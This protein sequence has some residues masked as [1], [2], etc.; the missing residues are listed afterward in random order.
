MKNLFI[1]LACILVIT[2]CKTENDSPSKEVPSTEAKIAAIDTSR[3]PEELLNVF[4]A[5]GGLQEWSEM[6]SM[7][8][9]MDDQSTI[10]D[11]KSRDIMLEAPNYSIGSI[12]GKVWIAQDST[13]FP[14]E[15]ARFYHNLM[16]YFYA[17]PFL[18]ADDG[19]VYSDAA[20]L[21]KDGLVYPGIKIGYEANVGDAPD[22]NYIL[23]YHPETKKMEW[24]AYTVTYGQSEK[25]NEYSYIKYNKW[26]EVNGLLLPKELTWYK[27]E[28]NK[29]TVSAGKTRVFSKVDIDRGGLDKQTFKMPE[30]GIYVD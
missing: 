23:Y 6:K 3:Y 15:R 18:L 5:H 22:D 20:P 24:L 4:S 27:V 16:F 30:N 21:E 26:Q 17:M 10:T 1:A 13:Y 2:S 25:S 19:I 14:K 28:E 8:Y 7:T 12:N 9:N 29:P 11:L